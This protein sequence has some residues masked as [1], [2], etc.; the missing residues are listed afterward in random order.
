MFELAFAKECPCG[1]REGRDC[2]LSLPS[3]EIEYIGPVAEA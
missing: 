1:C 3:G 2:H